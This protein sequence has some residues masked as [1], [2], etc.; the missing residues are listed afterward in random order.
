MQF[1][2]AAADLFLLSILSMP[3]CQKV[4]KTVHMKRNISVY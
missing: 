3:W 1:I 4:K 2:L